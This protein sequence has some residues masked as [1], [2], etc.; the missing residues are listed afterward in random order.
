MSSLLAVSELAEPELTPL[1]E[2]RTNEGGPVEEPLTE[3]SSR[4]TC[5]KE[6]ARMDAL[7]LC[8][9]PNL[10]DLE[11][12]LYLA[13]LLMNGELPDIITAE[14]QGIFPV[15]MSSIKNWTRLVLKYTTSDSAGN[16]SLTV[17]G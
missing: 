6:E 2:W 3:P 17:F 10:T 5:D 15:S 1:E 4:L 14:S 7:T 11:R 12:K 8:L 16:S 13:A 9:L